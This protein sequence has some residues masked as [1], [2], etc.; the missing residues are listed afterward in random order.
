MCSDDKPCSQITGD[1]VLGDELADQS[2]S[3]FGNRPK[4][5]CV[6]AAEPALELPLCLS[7]TRVDLP[8][9]PAGR[10]KP[11]VLGFKQDRARA[12]LSQMQG[13]G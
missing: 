2:F 8:T 1:G 5:V 7:V 3:G 10:R 4:I 12:R 6:L 9:I 11:Y 13:G